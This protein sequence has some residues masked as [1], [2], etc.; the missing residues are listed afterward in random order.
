MRDQKYTRPVYVDKDRQLFETVAHC[1]RFENAVVNHFIRDTDAGINKQFSAVT[2]DLDNHS[3]FIAF[4]GTDGSIVGWKE[5][6][7]MAFS[8]PIPAQ[9]QAIEYLTLLAGE[10]DCELYVGG[11]SKGGN[12]AVYAASFVDDT[13]FTRINRVYNYDGP[14]LSDQVNAEKAYQR[15][16]AKACTI[17]PKASMIGMLLFQNKDF[18]IVESD[19][20]SIMQHSPFYW[21]VLG[22]Q[23][24]RGIRSQDSEAMEKILHAWLQNTT[25]DERQVL[26][27]VFFDVVQ[28]TGAKSFN[29]FIVF[30]LFQSPEIVLKCLQNIDPSKRKMVRKRLSDLMIIIMREST[31]AEQQMLKSVFTRKEDNLGISNPTDKG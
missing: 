3:R 16:G 20:I 14:G 13:I 31:I 22:N 11:H 10:D 26:I 4:R 28:A 29:R 9:Q 27:D 19:A 12:L 18:T 6:F 7:N 15:L 1:R 8:A 17:L 30:K 25:D 23:F 21:H 24:V 5:D 2:F